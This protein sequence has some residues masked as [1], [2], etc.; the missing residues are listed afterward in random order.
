MVFF[1]E[2][3]KFSRPLVHKVLLLEPN[4][5]GAR[6]SFTPT[7]AFLSSPA[8]PSSFYQRP[9]V[10][11][12][13]N[14]SLDT[15]SF[16]FKENILW[17]G[18]SILCLS[19]PMFTCKVFFFKCLKSKCF[20]WVHKAIYTDCLVNSYAIFSPL[21]RDEETCPELPH[22][23]SCSEV[24]AGTLGPAGPPVSLASFRFQC[25]LIIFIAV[26]CCVSNMRLP[27]Y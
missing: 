26:I 19:T 1:L 20:L 14:D 24:N 2:R 4:E 13:F 5:L 23:C 12:I 15:H 18:E 21:Q 10:M 27:L 25:S 22:S 17:A 6:T 3:R 8:S 7:S 11:M 9:L 16:F